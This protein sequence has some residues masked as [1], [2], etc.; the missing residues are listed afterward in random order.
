[1]AMDHQ[2]NSYIGRI[3]Q[4]IS[5][6]MEPLGF[7]WKISVSLLSG[8]AAKEIVVSTLSVLYTGSDDSEQATDKNDV[9]R[10]ESRRNRRLYAL[11]RTQSDAVCSALLPLYSYSDSHRK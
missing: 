9:T 8:M 6:V 7:N 3:G 10:K 4:I 11:G 1:M 2:E 5:P